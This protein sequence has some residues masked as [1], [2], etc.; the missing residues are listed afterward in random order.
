MHPGTVGLGENPLGSPDVKS[1]LHLTAY[2]FHDDSP[3]AV[4][5][6]AKGLAAAPD[7]SAPATLAVANRGQSEKT[8]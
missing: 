1:E 8:R 2:V 4:V 5:P 3:P 7:P 6:G